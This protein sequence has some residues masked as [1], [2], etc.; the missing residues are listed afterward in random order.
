MFRADRGHKQLNDKERS[1]VVA[2]TEFGKSISEICIALNISRP[3]VVHWKRRYEETGDVDR[4]P[5]SGRPR[6]TTSA[7]DLNIRNAVIAK[8]ITTAQEIA[9]KPLRNIY[10]YYNY[11]YFQSSINILIL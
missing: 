5:G 6:K 7:E 1:A 4:Q 2:L 8:P 11:G 9:G 3:T 10:S